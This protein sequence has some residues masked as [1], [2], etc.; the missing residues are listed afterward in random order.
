M[1]LL[2]ENNFREAN[3][4]TDEIKVEQMKKKLAFAFIKQFFEFLFD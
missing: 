2:K 1:K 4:Q 3:E